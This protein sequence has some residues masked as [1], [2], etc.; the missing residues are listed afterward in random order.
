MGN[1]PN[2]AEIRERTIRNRDQRIDN[3][4]PKLEEVIHTNKITKERIEYLTRLD[5]T[6]LVVELNKHTAT[7]EQ[8]VAIYAL[9][10]ATIGR[11]HVII[12]EDYFE[13]ALKR[14]Q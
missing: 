13:Y 14:A 11:K 2:F 1:S 5:L 3:F 9:R 7:S 10:A 12:T 8:L 4:L 6:G